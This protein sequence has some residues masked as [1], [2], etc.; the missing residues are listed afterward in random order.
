[1]QTCWSPWIRI[2]STT[3]QSKL[4][5][6]SE[7][8]SNPGSAGLNSHSLIFDQA[9]LIL[10]PGFVI[11]SGLLFIKEADHTKQD[12]DVDEYPDD[13]EELDDE[14]DF[15]EESQKRPISFATLDEKEQDYEYPD[16]FEEDSEEEVN[17]Q[18]K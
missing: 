1:M 9:A 13:F 7:W 17:K 10:K 3:G 15:D 5:L 6:W 16:D 11:L 8:G 18:K 14:D 4:S 12:D 2:K